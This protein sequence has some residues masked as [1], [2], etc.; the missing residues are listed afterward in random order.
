VK[1]LIENSLDTIGRLLEKVEFESINS[2]SFQC[3]D[4]AK[5]N[6]YMTESVSAKIEEKLKGEQLPKARKEQKKKKKQL[7]Q[8]TTP[9]KASRPSDRHSSPRKSRANFTKSP[10]NSPANRTKNATEGSNKKTE[11]AATASQSVTPE[12]SNSFQFS[13]NETSNQHAPKNAK[14]QKK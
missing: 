7:Q 12:K 2:I 8:R 6:F 10:N 4:S 1:Q 11:N 13:K 3:K 14:K 5:F 9:K